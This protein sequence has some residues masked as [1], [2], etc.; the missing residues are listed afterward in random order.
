MNPDNQER[1]YLQPVKWLINAI[2][3]AAELQHGRMTVCD[4]EAGV[5]GYE[6][7]LYGIQRSF[8]FTVHG[9]SA[10]RASVRIDLD[11]DLSDRDE[12]VYMQFALIESLM[13]RWSG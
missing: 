10:N 1:I 8:L 13:L 3:D 11:G 12:S 4:T 5:I 9:R 7:K 2:L 6:T